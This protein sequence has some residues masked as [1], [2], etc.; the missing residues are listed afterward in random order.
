MDNNEKFTSA[1][2]IASGLWL[3]NQAASQNLVFL[4]DIDVIINCTKHIPFRIGVKEQM[5]K[6][7]VPLNDP[8]PPISNFISTTDPNDDQVIMTK[9]LPGLTKDIAAFRKHGK[10]I[11]I[12][13]HAGAQ[14]SAAMMAAYLAL[15]ASWKLPPPEYG[16]NIHQLRRIKFRQVRDI[17]ISKRPIAFHGGLSVNFQPAL[18]RFLL[19][20]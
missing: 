17:I 11:L 8:G 16:Y 5:I 14:R 3:G 18:N 19:L 10:R 1:T 7:R 9:T 4:K 13:C 20:E 6:I 15:Y 12:H 2:E